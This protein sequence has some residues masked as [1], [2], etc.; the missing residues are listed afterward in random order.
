MSKKS[1]IIFKRIYSSKSFDDIDLWLKD[2]RAN[3]N[4]DIKVFLIG[5]KA[6]LE[7][8][9]LV[10]KEQALQLQKDF[11]LD[12]FMETSA[13]TGFNTQELFIEA[14]K[15]LFEDYNKYKLKPKKSGEKLKLEND[16]NVNEN[17]KKGC[18]K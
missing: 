10:T 17:K 12:L 4:P 15:I 8:S 1:I 14:A 2:L 7:D 13:K 6:D 5:N 11:E 9:R 3:S 18:C 16:N